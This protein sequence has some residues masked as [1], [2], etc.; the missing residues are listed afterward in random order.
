MTLVLTRLRSPRV[1]AYEA[2]A[3]RFSVQSEVPVCRWS[4]FL[5]P[6]SRC[7]NSCPDHLCAEGVLETSRKTDA[8]L[9]QDLPC[10]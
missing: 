3:G 2:G 4:R 8:F 9:A 10:L 6:W 5:S 7:S 1:A